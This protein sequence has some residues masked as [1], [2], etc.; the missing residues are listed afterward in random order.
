MS[1]TSVFG[2]FVPGDGWLF[3]LGVGWKY[4]IVLVVTL[5]PLVVRHWALTVLALVVVLLLLRL[6]GVALARALNFGVALWGLLVILTAYHLIVLN[7]AAAVTHPGNLLIAVLASRLLTL[8]TPIPELLDALVRFLRPL[9]HVGVDPERFGLAVALVL[10]SIPYLAGATGDA[11]EAAQARGI[12][13]NPA[14]LLVP[15]LLS[16]VAYAQRTAEALT[17]RGLGEANRLT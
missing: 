10:R 9:R 3:R 17:A 1:Y 12:R 2:A 7:P 16:A 6:G 15:V 13:R 4:L 5:P 11:Q 8:T 14:L